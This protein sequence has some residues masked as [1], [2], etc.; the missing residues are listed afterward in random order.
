M[1]KNMNVEIKT[2][3]KKYNYKTASFMFE[4]KQIKCRG[5]TQKEAD[6]KAG[7]LKVKLEHGESVLSSETTV[8]AWVMEWFETY[9]AISIDYGTQKDYVCNMKLIIDAIGNMRLKDVKDV[10][11]QKILNS[12]A[13]KSKS[14]INKIYWLIKNIFTQARISRL[15]VYSPAEELKKPKAKRPGKRRSITEVEREY[16]LAMAEKHRAGVW[17]KIMLYAGLRPGECRALDWRH[18]DFKKR[19]ISVQKAM[20]HKTNKIGDPKSD[21]GI[22][23]IPMKDELYDALIPIRGEPYQPVLTT[24]A[25]MRHTMKS[26]ERLWNYFKRAL[27]ISRGAE[28]YRNKIFVS[29]LAPDLIPYFLR[30][31]YGSDLIAAGVDISVVSYLMGHSSVE[32]TAKTYVHIQDNTLADV[33]E[34]INRKITKRVQDK[35]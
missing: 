35:K 11:L 20:K 8:S 10:H 16:I 31:T 24:L 15:I 4:G 3:K 14:Y 6:R 23:L 12:I 26:M 30:H 25:G 27:D 21:A 22:R 9:K 1:T 2:E 29:T 28:M 34:K 19:I 13:G 7:E 5:K 17:L 18:V 32:L 33:A